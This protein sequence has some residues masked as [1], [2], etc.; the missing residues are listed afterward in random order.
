MRRTLSTV[1]FATTA[2][3]VMVTAPVQAQRTFTPAEVREARRDRGITPEAQAFLSAFQIVRDY[4]VAAVADSTV[5]NMAIEGLIR[6]L[7]DPYAEVFTPEEFDKFQEGNT[8]NYAG[9]GVQITQLNERITITAVFRDTP[10]QRTGLMVGDLILEVEGEP[11]TDWT[12]AKTSDVIR[13]PVGEPVA[14]TIGRPGLTRPMNVTL[15]R[16]TVHV[17]SVISGRVA[18]DVGYIALDRVARESAREI[19]DA[20]ESLADTR[21]V[22]LD[23]RGNPGGFMDES[24]MISDLFL[25]PG[26]TLLSIAARTPGASELTIQEEYKAK[27]I[28]VAAD[29]PVIVLVDGFSASA[30][31]IVAGALQDNDRALVVGTRTFGKGVFQNVFTLTETRHL[32]LTTGEWYT[33]LGRSLHRPRTSSGRPLPEDPDTF[34]T[35]MTPGGRELTAGGGV[36]PDLQ[37]PNDTLTLRERE[38]L[39]QAAGAN[40]PLGLRIEEFAFSQADARRKSGD[41]PYVDAAAFEAF[42][43]SMVQEDVEQQFVDDDD[44]RDYLSWRVNVRLSDRMERR[45]VS[46][47]WRRRRDPVL[48]EAVRL[49]LS[50]DSQAGLFLAADRRKVELALAAKASKPSDAGS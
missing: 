43:A 15:T 22:I 28:P 42:L 49:L 23:L 25:M 4:G 44:I 32:R 18:G 10:A 33:P 35:V 3:L 8:G 16:D 27:T 2:A 9:I 29:K 17:T 45:D 48:D 41:D 5:W 47:E 30:S 40:Y 14:I 7:N 6:E 38:F 24:L 46:L 21:G 1:I 36:F 39:S 37:I 50:V 34:R 19:Q 20:L 13:G 12:T 31:E 26:K 11:T